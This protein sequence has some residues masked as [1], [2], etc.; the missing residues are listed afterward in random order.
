MREREESP[1]SYIREVLR[2]QSAENRVRSQT[3][4]NKQDH[5]SWYGKR[6]TNHRFPDSAKFSQLCCFWPRRGC[7]PIEGQI[8]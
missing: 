7:L 5:S 4:G 1:N 8:E 6:Q 3:L 2:S